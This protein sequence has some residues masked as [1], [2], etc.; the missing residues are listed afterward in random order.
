[1][2]RESDFPAEWSTQ[3]ANK[4]SR[5]LAHCSFFWTDKSIAS[6]TEAAITERDSRNEFGSADARRHF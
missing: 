2:K 5:I 1:M 6:T 4:F 3:A